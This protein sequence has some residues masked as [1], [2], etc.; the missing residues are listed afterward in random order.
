I[1]G[2]VFRFI[3]LKRGSRLCHHPAMKNCDV[4][5]L[6]QSNAD[7]S[8]GGPRGEVPLRCR[9]DAEHGAPGVYGAAPPRRLAGAGS[10]SIRRSNPPPRAEPP[11]GAGLRCDSWELANLERQFLSHLRLSGL[12][13]MLLLAK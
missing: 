9:S 11:R 3:A 10:R 6:P 13:A 7:I 2:G 12:T 8:P 1:R 4:S 5:E